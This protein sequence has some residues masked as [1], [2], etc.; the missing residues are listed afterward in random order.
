MAQFSKCYGVFL[1]LFYCFKNFAYKNDS[2]Q[3]ILF[4]LKHIY[5]LNANISFITQ[6][7]KAF[8]AIK[9]TR[10]SKYSKI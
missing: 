2:S 10:K 4:K 6:H 1:V 3:L 7:T 5:A 9:I 8:L